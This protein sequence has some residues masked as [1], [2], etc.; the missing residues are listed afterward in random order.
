[1]QNKMENTKK[2]ENRIKN[3]WGMRSSYFEK[4]RENELLN[5]DIGN[6]WIETFNKY[7]SLE[8][9]ALNILDIGTGAGYF[10][11]LLDHLGHRTTGIDL[12][13][14][15]ISAAN[16]L[17]S[18]HHSNAHFL[19]MDAMHLD[20]PDNNFDAIVT[21]NLTWTLPDV[22]LAYREWFRVLKS[23]GVLINFDANYGNNVRYE[24]NNPPV[25]SQDTP[26]D[27][28]P[29]MDD[30]RKENAEITLSME[31]SRQNR[32]V[33]DLSILPSCGFSEFGADL[34]AGK[35]IMKEWD[36]ITSPMFVV[37]AKKE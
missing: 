34:N 15:M 22:P 37:W 14:E 3:Y 27:H 33:W 7:V 21:R 4:T 32:P 29:L 23:G 30:M 16:D 35:K 20:F 25:P 18:K 24:Q 12:T 17:A 1:M 36:Q 8:Q 9:T 11:I 28:Q 26:F 13:P 19:V 2:L 5:S 6:R 10:A 31:A